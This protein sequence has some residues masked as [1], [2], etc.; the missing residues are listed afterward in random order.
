MRIRAGDGE[1]PDYVDAASEPELYVI[2]LLTSRRYAGRKIGDQL[3]V[4]AR[5]NAVAKGVSLM[6]VDCYGG[7]TGDLVRYYERNGFV[8]TQ[9]FT[10]RDWPCQVL[11]QRL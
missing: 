3:L 10:L 5:A 4:K 9:A 1:S 8:R 11:E 6:R 2:L 7:G